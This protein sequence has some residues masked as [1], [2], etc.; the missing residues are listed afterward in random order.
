MY[1]KDVSFA[2]CE[3]KLSRNA[4][5][6]QGY[7]SVFG[8]VD[9]YGDTIEKGAFAST[10]D[11]RKRMPLMLFGHNPGRVIG[12]WLN[13]SE[14]SKGLTGEGEFTPNHTD[15]QNA[16][17]SMKHGAID[18]LSIGFR[19]PKGG[20]EDKKEGGRI[21]RS[22]DLVEISVVTMPADDSARVVAVKEQ[23][24]A[25][26]SLRDVEAYLRD[27]G[28][29][30]SSAQTL[31]SRIKALVLSDSG[32]GVDETSEIKSRLLKL[33]QKPESILRICK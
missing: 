2:E 12:K 27:S 15:A 21:I 33:A 26:A 17:A 32:E 31:L 16:Y 19:I 6:F 4:G 20:A 13:L 22:I 24:E 25:I 18:G 29:S 23:L 10:L 1:Q 3:I 8:G 9:S 5:R 28:L 30:R 7:A 14:D 11:G